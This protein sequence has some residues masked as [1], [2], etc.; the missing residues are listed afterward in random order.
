MMNRPP[1]A[2]LLPL[3]AR[4][5]DAD[6]YKFRPVYTPYAKGH[7]DSYF[8]KTG[9]HGCWGNAL[10]G[11]GTRKG[12]SGDPWKHY[13]P[14]SVGRHWAIPG[15]VA[16]DLGIDPDLTPQEKL[17]ALDEAGFVS[18]PSKG[19][20]AMP[21][22]HQ[23][24][25]DSPGMRIQDIWSYQPHTQGVLYGTDA[26]IDEDVRWLVRQGDTE[27]LGY[28]TQKPL[29]LLERVIRSSTDEG[30]LVLD[31]F[32]GCGTTVTAAQTLK[33][34]WVGI[35]IT[36]LAIALIKSR[37]SLVPAE[38]YS[39]SGEPTTEEDAEHLAADDP[40]QFH[41]GRSDLWELARHRGRRGRR[42]DRW[43]TLLL[44]C[45]RV[46]EASN[47]FSQGGQGSGRLPARPD[48]RT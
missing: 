6:T 22:Y 48:R 28:P 20:D 32:C 1:N 33:R 41:G 3:G 29:G 42:G 26:G 39:V 47:P 31:P 45:R 30:D 2:F 19:S 8:K 11:A 24:L 46:S 23:Y 13:N 16:E 4:T 35:D 14:T 40:Y 36:Y 21:T 7:V 18:H 9:E 27:R 12:L 37:L 34:R 10:T 15:R 38:N 44:R 43:P 17:D 25:D 5:E